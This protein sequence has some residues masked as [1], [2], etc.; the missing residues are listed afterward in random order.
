[1]LKALGNIFFY[2][3]SSFGTFFHGSGF[4]QIGSWFL[5]D[6][7]QEKKP[8]PKHC[9]SETQLN[10][11]FQRHRTFFPRKLFFYIYSKFKTKTWIRI[12]IGP[13]SWIRIQIQYIWIPIH[14]TGYNMTPRLC[15]NTVPREKSCSINQG[16]R[17]RSRSEPGF[18][19][20]AGIFTRLRLWLVQI[21]LKFLQINHLKIFSLL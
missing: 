13:K 14:N 9:F 8:D 18:L 7:D 5:A 3:N 19:A 6:L 17:S 10:K 21:L 12:K 15:S 4:F 2:F 16:C 20:G 1:M 11:N